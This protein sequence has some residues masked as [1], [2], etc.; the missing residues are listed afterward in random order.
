MCPQQKTSPDAPSPARKSLTFMTDMVIYFKLN[1]LLREGTM[2]AFIDTAERRKAIALSAMTPMRC[3]MTTGH[4]RPPVFC[5]LFTGGAL[6][7]G[8]CGGT[9][10]APDAKLPILRAASP[11]PIRIS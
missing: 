3:F 10:L 8:A 9:A 4:N 5:L 7:H 2:P 6:P 1:G 11:L